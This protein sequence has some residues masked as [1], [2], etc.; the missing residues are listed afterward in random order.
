MNTGLYQS[1]IEQSQ[2][3][4]AI[5]DENGIMAVWNRAMERITGILADDM[6]GLKVW[7][8]QFALLPEADQTPERLT[9][10]KTNLTHFLQT[11]ESPVANK[12]VSRELIRPNGVSLYVEGLNFSIQTESGY[13]LASF[14]RDITEFHLTELA[15]KRNEQVLHE[16]A[17]QLEALFN[18]SLTFA[19]LSEP[20][21]VAEN[22]LAIL[23]DQMGYRRGAIVL[24]D[25]EAGKFQLLAHARM[26]L[27]EQDFLDEIVRVQRFFEMESGITRWVALHGEVVR[28]G[29]VNAD[30]RYLC[31]DPAIQSELAVPLQVGGETIGAINV[32][33]EKP[34]AFDENDER[35][36][37]IL[38]NQAAVAI[39]NARLFQDTRLQAKEL[40][41]INTLSQRVSQTLSLEDCAEA[42]AE[43]I[44]DATQANV[45]FI[46]LLEGDDL[47]P[48][49]VRYRNF[50]RAFKG[51]PTHKIGQCLCGLA[52]S[53]KRLIFSCPIDTDERC[54]WNE[55]KQIG[56][57][58][59]AVVP[60]IRGDQV[61]GIVGLGT[62]AERNYDQQKDFI[63][64]LGS[65][66][67]NGIHNALLFTQEQ[68][69]LREAEALR[70]AA[71]SITARLDL[72]EV[73][74]GIL[75]GLAIVITY[76][77]A[78]LFLRRDGRLH[79][80]AGRGFPDSA[81]LLGAKF[82]E[83]EFTNQVYETRRP[84]VLEDALTED[85]F[86]Q[87]GDVDYIRGWMLLPLVVRNEVIGFM[88]VDNRIPNA[89]R[90]ADAEFAT[91]FASQAAIAVDNARL[92]E[93]TKK[94]QEDLSILFGV[95]QLLASTMQMESVLQLIAKYA[96][97]LRGL[98]SGAIYLVDGE[99]LLLG[100]T[101][102][103]L[104]ADFPPELR[105]A[106]LTDHPHIAEALSSRK[107]VII[108]DVSETSL[109]EAE[110]AV[111][112][113]RML[114]SILY[115]PLLAGARLVGAL[116]L[117]STNG[118]HEFLPDE[119][120]LYLSLANQ[121][122]LTIENVRL[123]EASQ[124]HAFELEKRVAERTKEL[125][126]FVNLMAGR[127]VRMA[128]LK[129]AIKKLRKQLSDAGMEPIANDPLLEPGYFV[130]DT[131]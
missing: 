74:G 38:A 76:D 91:A 6:L 3:G 42:A 18:A 128:E 11:G 27:A 54:T 50:E 106:N 59:A 129:K 120:E 25:I 125:Q 94:R 34:D 82:P 100:A 124:R 105:R 12:L 46:M 109:S 93:S 14:T 87:W 99:F 55:C 85:G 131:R 102:P 65:V 26:G 86:K 114:C 31:A 19:R 13:M 4:I 45:G 66:I 112:E 84:L 110:R 62:E 70:Q 60:L 15:L 2:D 36:L 16:K 72:Q 113:L 32:E 130:E 101:T 37:M 39:Q 71:S 28:L 107:P 47:I 67:A 108:S 79:L 92:F 75:D 122:A 81:K 95:S 115:V 58:S 96:T 121:A 24:Y 23:E 98:G 56:L 77:S 117:A 48:I 89:Y 53:E 88:S 33:S 68:Q 9:Q 78:A 41:A 118:V 35:L 103:P 10:L 64:T 1:V 30:P 126:T 49:S 51:L 97:Q 20:R 69:R 5:C 44:L 40:A 123:Y 127:E 80:L 83:D 21:L 52:V 29:D 17:K 57:R 63:E 61:F 7:E 22:V 111:A 73:L 119:I 90:E 104:P 43:G 116:I 8:M